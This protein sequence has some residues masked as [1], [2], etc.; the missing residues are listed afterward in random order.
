M[1][2]LLRGDRTIY[3]Q[4]ILTRPGQAR[5]AVAYPI[6]KLADILRSMPHDQVEHMYDY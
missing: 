4:P 1:R 2:S 6:E 3:L 5:Y